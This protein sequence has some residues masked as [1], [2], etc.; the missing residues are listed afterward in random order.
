[1]RYGGRTIGN[2]VIWDIKRDAPYILVVDLGGIT[3]FYLSYTH[4]LLT[5]LFS[6]IFAELGTKRR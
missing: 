4:H 6:Y 2:L 3:A 5:S 1:M